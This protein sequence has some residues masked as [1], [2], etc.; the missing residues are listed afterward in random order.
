MGCIKVGVCGWFLVVRNLLDLHKL[1]A[2]E[3]ESGKIEIILF[4]VSF[5]LEAMLLALNFFRRRDREGAGGG[6]HQRS[7]LV[8][9]R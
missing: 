6:E 5:I 9:V 7:I 2:D 1:G 8:A 3:I 4:S